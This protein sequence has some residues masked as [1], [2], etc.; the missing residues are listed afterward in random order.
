[1]IQKPIHP[2]NVIRSIEALEDYPG[3]QLV[4]LLILYSSG[5]FLHIHN[6][7]QTWAPEEELYVPWLNRAITRLEC[8]E[9]HCRYYLGK[10]RDVKPAAFIFFPIHLRSRIEE[11]R[12]AVPSPRWIEKVAQRRQILQPKLVRTYA[13]REMK[14]VLGDTDT[15]K[16]I[17][18]KF[19]ELTVSARHYM[20]L[21]AEADQAYP[22]Y[23]KHIRAEL[24][25]D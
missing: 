21:L 13:L 6:M 1:M 25:L 10:E 24:H 5:R 12:D 11:Y 7:L 14:R 18:G 19:G 2:E 22:A 17:V 4:Y 3:I 9:E 8:L 16:F 15:Y 23:I 20:D